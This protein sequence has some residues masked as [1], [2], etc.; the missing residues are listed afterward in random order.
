MSCNSCK[1]NNENVQIV[2]LC[3]TDSIVFGG[4]ANVD[5]TWTEISIPEVLTIPCEK[6]DVEQI[7]TVFV[8]VKIV[9]K[10]VVETPV[11]DVENAEGTKLTGKKLI[12]EGNLIQKIVYTADLPDQPVH[13][14]H[15]KVPFSAFI[16]LDNTDS[17]E[18]KFCV[19]ACVEDV[20]VKVFN[21]RDIFKNVTLFLHAKLAP[22]TPVCVEA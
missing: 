8:K 9:S 16:V 22:D 20:F 14:A 10:R 15:F 3:D 4:N 5:Y 13:S 21:K 19:E 1:M 18:D 6:P 11:A 2:G 7:E 12:I 17:V